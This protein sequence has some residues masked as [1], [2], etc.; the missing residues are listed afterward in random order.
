M[1]SFRDNLATKIQTHIF[2]FSG[3]PYTDCNKVTGTVSVSVSKP[4]KGYIQNQR[5]GSGIWTCSRYNGGSSV[6]D[7]GT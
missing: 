3:G 1:S 6:M 4:F 7:Q 2:Y 5:G